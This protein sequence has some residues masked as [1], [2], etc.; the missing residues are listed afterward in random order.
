MCRIIIKEPWANNGSTKEGAWAIPRHS[1]CNYNYLHNLSHL[2]RAVCTQIQLGFIYPTL[3][4]WGYSTDVDGIV[5]SALLWI[6]LVCVFCYPSAVQHVQNGHPHRRCFNPTHQDESLMC[7][8]G[9]NKRNASRGDALKYVYL[10]TRRE[11]GQ[12][13]MGAMRRR[14]ATRAS[15][16]WRV[17]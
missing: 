1:S 15:M 10:V 2:E 13:S 9:C 8:V 17:V 4:V 14:A 3:R 5:P 6:L 11:M 7:G 12:S 16:S